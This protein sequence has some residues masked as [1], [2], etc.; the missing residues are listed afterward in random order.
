MESKQRVLKILHVDPEKEWGGGETEVIDLLD[1]L[2]SWKHENHLLC[3]PGGPLMDRVEKKKT[4]TV[5]PISIRNELDI[6]VVPF[7]RRLIHKEAYDIVHFHTKRAH[8]LALYLGHARP[9][10]RFVVTRRMDYP[11]K[12][13]WYNRYL[14]NQC[15]DGIIALSHKIADVLVEAGIDRQK[16]RV[17]YTGINPEPFQKA[18]TVKPSNP[19]SVIGTT[20]VL[21]ERKGYQ[22][23]LE[24]AALLKQKGYRLKYR[25]AGEGSQRAALQ[26]LAVDL[27]L[28]EEVIFEG[29]VSD[30]PR[31]L[32]PIDV[33]VLPSLYEGMGVA[34]LEAMAAAKP[35]VGTT[36]G[37]IPELVADGITGLLV[38]PRNAGALARAISRLLSDK[39]LLT[40]MGISG[41]QRVQTDFTMEQT[42]KKVEHY[43]YELQQIRRSGPAY[44]KT[45]GNSKSI[46]QHLI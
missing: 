5:F 23:L 25:F 22:Y 14:Y 28:K 42:A 34:I 20:A 24:A 27:G 17:I 43:Y 30:I 12:Q 6:R 40:R 41:S 29:F 16:I 1:Y 18:A 38:P 31:F 10:M 44:P 19:V 4:I 7:L 11:V 33:F 37:G 15:V 36:V 32:S 35:V 39:A 26:N 2:S 45:F 46:S 13:K 3:H 21:E 8:A 9:E